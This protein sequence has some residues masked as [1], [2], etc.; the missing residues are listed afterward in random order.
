MMAAALAKGRTISKTPRASRRWKSWLWCSA[1]WAPTSKE[2]ALDD[3]DRRR[4]ELW[5]SSMRSCRIESRRARSWWR[6][7]SPR[8]TSFLR[9]AVPEHI[10]AIIAKLRDTGAEVTILDGGIRVRGRSEI[11]GVDITTQPHPGFSDGH[12]GQ[13]M[14]LATLAHGQSVITETFSKN[15]FMHVSELARLGADIQVGGERP[16]FEATRSFSA[17]RSWRPI[18]GHPPALF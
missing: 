5:G 9:G 14:V 12:A 10:E 15:R 7:H 17:R 8:A 16:S 11:R 4:D 6:R 1:R 18:Y 13:F 2:R 3:S